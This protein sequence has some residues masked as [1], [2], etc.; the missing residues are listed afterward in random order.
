[1]TLE[2]FERI[3]E[4]SAKQILDQSFA[5]MEHL[6]WVDKQRVQT[7]VRVQTWAPILKSVA[8]LVTAGIGVFLLMNGYNLPGT[9][10]IAS[11]V[12]S[13]V[14]PTIVPL[15]RRR[16]NERNGSSGNEAND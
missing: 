5:T 13:N 3:Q 4:G 11:S 10:M 12:G 8:T 15:F 1:M 14:I 16:G 7:V 6:R 9:L 2:A